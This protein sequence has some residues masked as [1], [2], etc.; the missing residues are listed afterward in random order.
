W[1][2]PADSCKA[3]NGRVLHA[4]SNRSLSYGE[5]AQDAAKR[6]P[7][8]NPKLKSQ[9]EFKLIGTDAVKRVDIPDKTRGA[10]M[11]GI[12]VELP[13]M[14]VATVVQSPVFGGKVKSI[15][16]AAAMALPGVKKVVDLG[17]AVGVI[18]ETYFHAHKA[19][20]AL[21][22]EWDEQGHGNLSTADISAQ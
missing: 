1:G 21:K 17:N 8:S 16:P 20:A 3:D 9:A 10:A 19:A 15:A 14:L 7:P 22:I 2:V 18:G 13:G 6:T 4:A 12:D 11:F 5:V